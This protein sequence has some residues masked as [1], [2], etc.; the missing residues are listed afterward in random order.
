MTRFLTLA[1]LAIPLPIYASTDTVR[2]NLIGY[3]TAAGTPRTSA[4][5]ATALQ[6]LESQA[7]E[8]TAPGFLLGDGSW[9][10][11]NYS[12]APSG[13]WSPW[14]HTQRL[15]VMARAYR[16]P[17]QALYNDPQ[18]RAQIEAALAYVPKYYGKKG[19]GPDEFSSPIGIAVAP[20]GDVY[21][22]DTSNKRIRVLG[23]N[24][25]SK[26]NFPVPAWG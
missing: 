2:T 9:S 25:E 26:R 24:G 22:A 16:T 12:E 5:L 11:I 15:L 18:L 3:Y 20:N 6:G 4:R 8:V 19:S 1:F 10:D 21:V 17:G 7:R 13:S 23:H 14:A